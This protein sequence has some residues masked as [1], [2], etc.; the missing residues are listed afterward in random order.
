[1]EEIT[2]RSFIASTASSDV[3]G[4]IKSR[5]MR[6]TGCVAHRRE[7]ECIQSFCRKI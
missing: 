4:V 2:M 3:T 1:M 5:R 6:W 7:R